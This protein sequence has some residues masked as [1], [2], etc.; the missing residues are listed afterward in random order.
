MRPVVLLEVRDVVETEPGLADD[1]ILV[2][3]TLSHQLFY[4]V[5]G[6]VNLVWLEIVTGKF[7]SEA[8]DQL[9]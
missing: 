3:T 9:V 1:Q 2:R 4:H 8:L 6:L 7:I 5:G